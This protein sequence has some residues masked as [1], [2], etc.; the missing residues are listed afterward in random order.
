MIYFQLFK[1]AWY[2]AKNSK[3][4]FVSIFIINAIGMCFA[5]TT[6][7]LKGQFFNTLQLGGDNIWPHAIFWVTL[8]TVAHFTHIGLWYLSNHLGTLVGLDVKKN[9]TK[10][11]YK[12]FTKL[13]INWHVNHHSGETMTKISQSVG[14]VQ[15]FPGRQATIVKIFMK[16]IGPVFLLFLFS[17]QIALLGLILSSCILI[18]MILMDNLKAKCIAEQNK[19]EQELG[20]SFLDGLTNIKTIITL[21]ISDRILKNIINKVENIKEKTLKLSI[22]SLKKWSFFDFGNFLMINIVVLIYAWQEYSANGL[23]LIGNVF[24]VYE[25]LKSWQDVFLLSGKEYEDLISMKVRSDEIKPLLQEYKQNYMETSHLKDFNNINIS[26]LYFAYENAK[27][28]KKMEFKNICL[29]LPKG[30]KIA[31]IGESGSGK[32]TILGILA[33]LFSDVKANVLIDNKNYHINAISDLAMLIPQEP[34]IFEN[35][36]KY[37]IDLDSR[38]PAA[39]LKKAIKMSKFDAVLKNSHCSLK[40][41]AKEKGLNLS[42]GEKQRLALA[43]GILAMKDRKIV[44]LDE[45]T[46]SIDKNNENLIYDSI[47]KEFSKKTIIAAVHNLKL[48]QKFDYVYVFSKGKIIEHGTPKKLQKNNGYFFKMYKKFK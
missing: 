2:F 10:E 41:D 16:F 6:P 9:A 19:S 1:R 27:T 18:G 17:W 3:K 13:P 33:G 28:K 4:K 11:Y 39:T 44:L 23:I 36:I 43:R 26:N 7:Y 15:E 12:T 47:L 31:F 8:L 32:S 29:D 46:S 20:S 22:F 34:E 40:T 42:G 38:Y 14:A 37:N 45:P 35:T 48:V 21:K 24:A 5:L 30:K 25:Y